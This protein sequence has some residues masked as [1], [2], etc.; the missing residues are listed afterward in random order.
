MEQN[1][2]IYNLSNTVEYT[3]DGD[4]AKTA[5]IEL[6]G[7]TMAVFDLS[8]Q[9]SQLVMRAMLDAQDL[10]DKFNSDEVSVEQ[11]AASIDDKAVKMILLASKSVKFSDVAD[12]C[13]KLFVKVGTY[14]GKLSLRDAAFRNIS[15]SDFTE[16]ICGYIANFIIPSLF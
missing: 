15:I 8:S 11:A 10:K 14:D 12:I 3:K 2:Y 5:T 9:L 4:F 16:M 6:H 7:P 13:K 1:P